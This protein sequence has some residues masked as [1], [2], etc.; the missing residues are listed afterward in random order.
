MADQA[1][2]SSQEAARCE[3]ARCGAARH[4]AARTF[5]LAWALAG[6]SCGNPA[7]TAPSG[8]YATARATDTEPDEGAALSRHRPQSLALGAT[9]VMNTVRPSVH[10]TLRVGSTVTVDAGTWTG[11]RPITFSYKYQVCTDASSCAVAPGLF[12]QGPR[13]SLLLAAGTAG[14]RLKVTVTATNPA[15]KRSVTTALTARPVCTPW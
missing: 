10:G 1:L 7:A 2:L 13:P 3:T 8:E 6:G 9:P 12:A 15:G 14:K 5:A 11:S 4:R